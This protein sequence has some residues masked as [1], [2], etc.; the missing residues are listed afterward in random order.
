MKYKR[1]RWC[2]FPSGRVHI[3]TLDGVVIYLDWASRRR[4]HKEETAAKSEAVEKLATAA[5]NLAEGLNRA[6]TELHRPDKAPKGA[7]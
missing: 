2:D 7:A 6:V 4:M 1:W 3:G 5:R